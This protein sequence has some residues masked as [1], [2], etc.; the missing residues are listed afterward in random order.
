MKFFT[1][2]NAPESAPECLPGRSILG[3]RRFPFNH[4]PR[5]Q[6]ALQRW[7][8]TART[9]GTTPA[10]AIQEGYGRYWQTELLVGTHGV[11]ETGMKLTLTFPGGLITDD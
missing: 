11:I 2:E 10:E 6:R 4:I 5:I 9:E 8:S 3:C 1:R 7:H